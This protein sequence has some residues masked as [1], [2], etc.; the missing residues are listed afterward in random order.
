MRFDLDKVPAMHALFHQAPYT[1]FMEF[2]AQDADRRSVLCST[3]EETGLDFAE[4]TLGK[5]RHIAVF[6]QGKKAAFSGTVLTAHYDRAEGS[7]GANDNGAA[8]F[9][10]V[11]AAMGFHKAK[12]ENGNE[13]PPVIFFTDKEELKTGETLEEQGA[14]A[15]AFYLKENRLDGKIF[16]FDA[17]GSGD[18]LIISTAADTLMR[19][20]AGSRTAA[21]RRRVRELRTTALE[22]ARAAAIKKVLLLPTP[23]S[24]DAGFFRAG[25]CA[26]TITVLPA[27]EAAAFSALVRRQG[28]FMQNGGAEQIAGGGQSGAARSLLS[29]A[30]PPP[31]DRR[32]IPETWRSLNGPGD[33]H[34]RLTTEHWKKIVAFAGA[35]GR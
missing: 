26:Q 7:P 11:D 16:T 29:S 31:G 23:F 33:S 3:L 6:P 35:L 2:I 15:L 10:L 22:A 5:N 24:D 30:V 1:R 25:L 20:A 17:C 28:G 9:M 4:I 34:I 14:Y 27:G 18:T 32:L 13:S 19:D 8:V 12:N 21:F